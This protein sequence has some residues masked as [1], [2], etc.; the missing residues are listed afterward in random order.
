MVLFFPGAI[1]VWLKESR[2]SLLRIRAGIFLKPDCLSIL[3][4]FLYNHANVRLLVHAYP[5]DT[6]PV[7][8]LVT[9]LNVIGQSNVLLDLPE[10]LERK[11]EALSGYSAV[12]DVSGLNPRFDGNYACCVVNLP[13]FSVISALIVYF[14]MNWINHSSMY[15]LSINSSEAIPLFSNPNFYEILLR[16]AFTDKK[17]WQ[18]SEDKKFFWMLMLLKDSLWNFLTFIFCK[19]MPW[20]RKCVIQYSTMFIYQIHLYI[21]D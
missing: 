18:W 13:I 21:L 9:S 6:I 2:C 17:R 7:K 19:Y 10:V 12:E 5:H 20:L 14:V 4:S 11:L 15:L 3:N 16:S 8:D 1:K